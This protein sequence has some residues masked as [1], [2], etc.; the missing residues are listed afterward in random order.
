MG[1]NYPPSTEKGDLK[2]DQA[3][4]L[5]SSNNTPQ[6]EGYADNDDQE[7]HRTGQE[8]ENLSKIE[9]KKILRGAVVDI[10]I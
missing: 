8:E 9:A 4:D 1:E 10:I 6:S 7:Y 5:F 2:V 3:F